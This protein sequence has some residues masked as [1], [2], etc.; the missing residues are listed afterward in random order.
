MSENT[1]AKTKDCKSAGTAFEGSSPSRPTSALS[2]E[3]AMPATLVS[4]IDAPEWLTVAEA[5]HLS[6]FDPDL[7]HEI[8]EDGGVDAEA[9]GDRW[10]I[11]KESLREYQEALVLVA[12]WRS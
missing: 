7:L 5:A 4:W 1:K 11:E 10:L 8:I 3:V 9:L 2:N 6:G 12:G